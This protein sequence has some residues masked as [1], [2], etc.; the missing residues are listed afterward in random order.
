MAV[1]T[2]TKAGTALLVV[3]GLTMAL[4]VLLSSCWQLLAP[5]QETI[6]LRR[7]HVRRVGNTSE[8]L[9]HAAQR[10]AKKQQTTH[11]YTLD[12]PEGGSGKGSVD[13]AQGSANIWNLKVVY[14]YK[15][16]STIGSCTI[17]VEPGGEYVISSWTVG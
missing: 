14:D 15:E 13:I 7:V 9:K 8:L 3:M 17:T 5:L 12:W 11:S 10:V 4:T 6:A 16:S 2:H 1:I